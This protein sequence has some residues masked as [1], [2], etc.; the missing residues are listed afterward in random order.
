MKRILSFI[1]F[2]LF[3]CLA[4]AQDMN[5]QEQAWMQSVGI[6][7]HDAKAMG[8][9]LEVERILNPGTVSP[10]AAEY[11]K[12]VCRIRLAVR[13]NPMAAQ[14]ESLV[15]APSGDAVARVASMAHEFGHCVHAQAL[16]KGE[17]LPSI[18]SAES[19]AMADVYALAW[20][21]YNAR[22]HFPT[23][24]AFFRKLRDDASS[25]YAL[26]IKA[27]DKACADTLKTSPQ[28][29]AALVR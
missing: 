19:E 9:T 14:V 1:A 26:S 4:H 2:A 17:D 27:I 3:T 11:E 16:E 25:K 12:G 6:F 18:H 8:M 22:S 13:N 5:R 21:A 29:A 24:L 23:A 28:Y 15:N 20:I 7:A 10:V